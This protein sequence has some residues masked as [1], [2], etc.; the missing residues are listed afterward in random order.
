MEDTLYEAIPT[1]ISHETPH[2]LSY[3][4]HSYDMHIFYI[5]PSQ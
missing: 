5:N 1:Q 3:S 2:Q 4:I